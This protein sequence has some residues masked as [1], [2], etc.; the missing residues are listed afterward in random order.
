MRS[1]TDEALIVPRWRLA[2]GLTVLAVGLI[3]LLLPHA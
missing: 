3:V 1:P 2:L